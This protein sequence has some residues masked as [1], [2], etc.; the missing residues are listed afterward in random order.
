MA[1][2]ICRGGSRNHLFVKW[3]TNVEEQTPEICLEAVK[4]RNHLFVKWLT[5][6]ATIVECL[7]SEG[8][9]SRNHLFVKWLTN[10]I[11]QTL[12]WD[13]IKFV[14]KSLIR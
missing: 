12:F 9:R 11:N 14:S 3:L 5:N 8:I 7:N 2:I 10:P 6:T 13:E 4:S 1:S